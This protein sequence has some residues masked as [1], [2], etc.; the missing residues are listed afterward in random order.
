MYF[1]IFTCS[2]VLSFRLSQAT[3]RIP[4]HLTAKF[5]F[6]RRGGGSAPP[7]V[8][9]HSC[10][11]GGVEPPCNVIISLYVILIQKVLPFSQCHT[12]IIKKHK[13]TDFFPKNK[14]TKSYFYKI[15]RGTTLIRNFSNK[16]LRSF[17]LPFCLRHTPDLYFF[18]FLAKKLS[19][20]AP[21]LKFKK[22]FKKI[23]LLTRFHRLL[24]S[25]YHKK[26]KNASFFSSFCDK[27]AKKYLNNTAK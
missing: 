6:I 25:L 10:F 1:L 5:C 18:V 17:H 26:K 27:C 13:K 11:S 22:F 8:M 14:G 15:I 9:F 21:T 7:V 24:F 4:T 20:K 23:L 16:K 2:I 19:P 12:D 3:R